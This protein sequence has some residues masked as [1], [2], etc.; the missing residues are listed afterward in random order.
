MGFIQR[1]D[2][3]RRPAGEEAKAE[4]G[5]PTFSRGGLPRRDPGAGAA[6]ETEGL[7][8]SGFKAKDATKDAAKEAPK[9]EGFKRREAPARDTAAGAGTGAPRGGFGFRNANKVAKK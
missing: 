1:S 2:K 5:R 6:V 4:T 8:R 3:V 9:D 7:S